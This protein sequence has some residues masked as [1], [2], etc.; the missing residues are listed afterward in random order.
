MWLCA[1]E[2]G[3]AAQGRCSPWRVVWL[4]T[5]EPI[6]LRR[7]GARPEKREAPVVQ[8]EASQRGSTSEVMYSQ[9]V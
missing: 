9:D 8:T 3:T 7:S 6:W 5:A 4:Q 1:P 2:T